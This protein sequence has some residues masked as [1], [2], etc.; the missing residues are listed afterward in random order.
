[1]GLTNKSPQLEPS[2]TEIRAKKNNTFVYWSI[3]EMIKENAVNFT[4]LLVL[5]IYTKIV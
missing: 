5:F 3:V 1:M 2:K 4:K